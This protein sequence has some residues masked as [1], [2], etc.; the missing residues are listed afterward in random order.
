[1]GGTTSRIRRVVKPI[2]L[3]ALFSGIAASA[4][5]GWVQ[6]GIDWRA[7]PSAGPAG[8]CFGNCG[9]D[10]SSNL[11]PCGGPRQYW[12]LAFTAGPD[13][14]QSG[15]EA[16]PCVE[17][18]YFIRKW[19]EFHAIGRWSYHGWVKPGCI[20]HDLYCNDWIIGC[21]LFFGCGSPGW[22][23]TWSYQEWMRGYTVGPWEYGGTC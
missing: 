20:T 5:A 1:M 13:R 8:D 22:T 9:A 19:D 12:D 16:S 23:D 17:N 18:Q 3:V 11:N 21:V 10:C 2:L 4:T 14:V 7:W 15:M 6:N